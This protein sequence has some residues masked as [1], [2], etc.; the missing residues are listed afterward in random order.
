[1]HIQYFAPLQRAYNRMKSVLFQP[2]DI[3]NWMVLGFTAFLADLLDG[4]SGFNSSHKSSQDVGA[5]LRAPY[6][7]LDWLRS[8]PE[9]LAL[10]VIGVVLVVALILLFLWL[11][12]RGKFM[13]LDNVVQR[14]ALIGQPWCQFREPAFSLFRW[15]IVFAL[16]AGGLALAVLYQVW[17]AAY[18]S[19]EENGDLWS[20]I[21]A[22]LHWGT[23]FLII[24]LAFGYV[25]MLLD[26]FIV[27]LMY[28][29][30]L[31]AGQAWEKFLPLHGNNLGAFVL[32][33]LTMLAIIVV[34]V[35]LII[36]VGLF[37][38]CLG[39]IL[40]AIPYIGSVVLL[41]FSYCIRCFSLEFLA[42]FGDEFRL[43]P[44]MEDKPG[45]SMNE[46]KPG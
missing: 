14:R 38:C 15:R 46:V 9:W 31:T 1:M 42:Q 12:S 41:P 10:I 40:L 45:F 35:V 32:Y 8:R 24:V 30:H 44:E 26:H 23:I 11:S 22:L 21:P 28:K 4:H 18:K 19:W 36:I 20:L 7:A 34:L 39:F 33:A 29:H 25:K 2:F 43:L 6:E 37:T 17:Q 5:V 3:R 13:F 27:P 16:I